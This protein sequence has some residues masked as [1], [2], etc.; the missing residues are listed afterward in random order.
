MEMFLFLRL[1]ARSADTAILRFPVQGSLVD[2]L[3]CLMVKKPCGFG[4]VV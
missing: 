2:L 3:S 1:E 4:A